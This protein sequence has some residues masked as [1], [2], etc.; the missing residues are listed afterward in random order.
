VPY[1]LTTCFTYCSFKL[2]G[3][4]QEVQRRLNWFL[5]MQSLWYLLIGAVV[6]LPTAQQVQLFA[7]TGNGW[8]YSAVTVSLVHANQLH[9]RDCIKALLVTYSCKHAVASTGL[10]L[11]HLPYDSCT[12]LSLCLYT[13]MYICSS[14]LK[15]AKKEKCIEELF[16]LVR[17]HAKSLIFAHDTSR[18]IQSLVKRGT[19]E[20]RDAIFHELKG[21]DIY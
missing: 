4:R 7:C 13:V 19:P 3:V 18:V 15:G 2:K 16:K 8:P 21:S 5:Y 10:H 11:Y 9:F 14:E 20:M 6:C 1:I 12:L 17:G